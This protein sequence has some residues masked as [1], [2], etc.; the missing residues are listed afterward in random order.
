MIGLC[1]SDRKFTGDEHRCT[2]GEETRRTLPSTS[3]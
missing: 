1:S 2:R 3:C